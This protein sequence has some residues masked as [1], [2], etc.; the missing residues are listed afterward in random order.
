MSNVLEED[1]GENTTASFKD[2]Q[3]QELNNGR[4][5]MV[6]IIGLNRRWQQVTTVEIPEVPLKP[7]QIYPGQV[8]PQFELKWPTLAQNFLYN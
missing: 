6:A 5:A 1:S 3:M 8:W 4:L 7:P 2:S